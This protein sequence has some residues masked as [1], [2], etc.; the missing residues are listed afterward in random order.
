[1]GNSVA[2][3]GWGPTISRAVVVAFDLFNN[4]GQSVP[5]VGITNGTAYLSTSDNTVGFDDGTVWSCWVD[6]TAAST[7]LQVRLSR[8]PTRP[9]TARVQATVNLYTILGQSSMYL[10]LS[11]SS[12]RTVYSVPTIYSWTFTLASD[13][14]FNYAWVLPRKTLSFFLSFL[15][16]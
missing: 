9:A 1:M 7:S 4:G 13:A 5:N 6:Y 15:F 16:F 12:S 8:T 11:A 14:M 2:S 3:N 10:S